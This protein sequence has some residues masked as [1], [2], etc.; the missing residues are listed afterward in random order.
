MKRRARFVDFIFIMNKFYV[1]LFTL[2]CLLV[3]ACSSTPLLTNMA[4]TPETISPRPGEKN[5]ATLITYALARPANVSVYLQDANGKYVL[6]EN[7]PRAAG[8]FQ[9]LFGGSVNNRTLND[10]AYQVVVTAQDAN[11]MH[12]EKTAALNIINAD[13]SLPELQNFTVFPQAFTP[14]QD[15]L[16]DRVIIRYYLTKPA[17]VTVYLTDGKQK[18][19]IDEKKETTLLTED[20]LSEIGPHE[21]DYDAGIDRGAPPPPDGQYTVVAE[22]VDAN[23]NL[24]RAEAPLVIQ[25]GGTP[26][27]AIIGS[28][29]DF[30]PR[31]VPLGDTLFF[32][33]TVKN[34]GTVPIRT[35]GPEPGFVYNTSQNFSTIE[36]YEE[37]GIWRL[38]V[39][40]EGNSIGRQ[41]PYRWQLGMDN[42]LTRVEREGK[43]IY[44]LMP[45]QVATISG[46]IKITD[47][48]PK[49]DPAYWFGLVQEQVRIVE[50]HVEPTRIT[51]DF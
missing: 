15:G 13:T 6:R 4:V 44:Y 47:K 26:R 45:G 42:E 29:G 50:D 22:A 38:G 16:D 1:L 8:D 12:E 24:V 32:T 21:Y 41:Y 9:I 3:T 51:V 11:G 37:P 33:V 14:N 28:A 35:K 46:G 27:A 7:Q 2:L 25:D 20:K 49:V 19:P 48:P 23:G 5:R 36:Q 18:F 39:D 17:R 34:V 30:N 40:S 10:G 31:V 43:T